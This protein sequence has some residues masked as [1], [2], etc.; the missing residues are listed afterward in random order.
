MVTG[1]AR[2]ARRSRFDVAREHSAPQRN[3][4]GRAVAG[5]VRARRVYVR[6]GRTPARTS[7]RAD[8][9]AGNGLGTATRPVPG[10]THARA[11]RRPSLLGAAS[12]PRTRVRLEESVAGLRFPGGARLDHIVDAA[13]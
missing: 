12:T 8:T 9:G 13:W 1:L 10:G 5:A 6:A 2:I 3:A 11:R 7:R 4:R